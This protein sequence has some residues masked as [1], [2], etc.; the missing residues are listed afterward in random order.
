[1]ALLSVVALVACTSASGST[2]EL[3][4]ALREGPGLAS[5]FQGFD[6]TDATSALEQLRT[7][8]VA[9]G[10]LKDAAPGEV[11]DD[12]Q[13]EIVYVQALIDALEPLEDDDATRVALTIQAV[14]DAHPDVPTAAATLE[15]FEAERC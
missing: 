5:V 9:L 13:V 10:D 11:R 4:Q 15:S 1:V 6:P 7:A 8:R 2:K 3:C 14:T 12:L